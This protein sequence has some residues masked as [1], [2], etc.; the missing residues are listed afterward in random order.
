MRGNE[1]RI[2]VASFTP[3]VRHNRPVRGAGANRSNS[4]FKRGHS[5]LTE[6][7]DDFGHRAARTILLPNED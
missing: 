1:T 7:A 5:T 2:A 6:T 4:F 3:G